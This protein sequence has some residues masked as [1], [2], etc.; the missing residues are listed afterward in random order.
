MQ[1]L[2]GNVLSGASFGSVY[3]LL[4]IGL[5]LA[6]KTSGIFNLAYGAQAFVSGFVALTCRRKPA[7]KPRADS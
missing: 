2:I 6:Y 1:E 5:V 7:G 4:A 3:A